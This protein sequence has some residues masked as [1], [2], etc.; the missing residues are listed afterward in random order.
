M[1]S[2]KTVQYIKEIKKIKVSKE[3][4]FKVFKEARNIIHNCFLRT[5]QTD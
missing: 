1:N 4:V 2:E 3:M 5:Y